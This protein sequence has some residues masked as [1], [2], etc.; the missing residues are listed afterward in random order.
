[1]NVWQL[2][3]SEVIRQFSS[4]LEGLSSS[5][6]AQRLVQ[7]GPNELQRKKE[8]KVL[9][10]L[11]S[12][13]KNAVVYILL[14]AFMIAA[15]L[16][17]WIDAG[18]IAAIVVLNTVLG[19][20]QEYKADK[21]I[22]KL[23]AL[24]TP[25]CRVMRDGKEQMIS[26]R[27]L[28]PGD[29]VLLEEGT[30]VPA[31]AYLLEAWNLKIDESLLTGESVPVKK[32]LTI[33]AEEVPV[34]GRE[35]MVFS[36][37]ITTYG[38]GKA[39]VTATGMQ[40]E[41]GKI[42]HLIQEAEEK[43]TPLQKK[44]DR[45][46]KRLAWV[47]VL[48]I[49]IIF[50]AGV[51][52]GQSWL[53]MFL[54]A[55]SLAVAAI[56][57]GLP[58]VVTISLA[59]GVRRMAK[60]R[61]LV[62]RLSAVET[63][64]ATTIICADKTGTLT[65]N[66][67]TVRKIFSNNQ[68]ID[69]TGA[70]YLPQGEFK[71]EGKSIVP[72][73]YT[74]LF[75]TALACN[76]ARLENGKVLGDPTEGALVVVAH[77]AG[78]A[79]VSPRIDEIPFTSEAKCMAT[80]HQEGEK[81]IWHYKGAPE[82]ILE[83]CAKVWLKG[84]TVPL[85]AAAKKNIVK[86][87]ESMAQDALRVLAFASGTKQNELT[88]LGL[89]GMIDPPRPSV[90]NAIQNCRQA[91]IRVVMITGDHPVTAQ[92]IA[93]K[94]GLN[95]QCLTGAALD[96]MDDGA[97]K[98]AAKNVDIYARVSPAHKVRILEALRDG[99]IIAMTGDGVNDA[100]ALKRADIGVAVGSATD[101]AKE[102][103]DMVLLDDDFSLIVGA[104]EEGRGIYDNIKKFVN[105][106]LSSNLGEVL[107]LFLAMMIGFSDAAGRIL[108]PLLAVHLLWINLVTDGLPA[109]ALGADPVSANVM[110]RKPRNPKEPLITANMAGNMGITALLMAAGGLL[111]FSKHQNQ[112][113][114][115]QTAVFTSIVVFEMVR[116]IMIR[117]QYHLPLFSN[118]WLVYAV[119]AS[120]ALQLLAVYMP[121][122]QLAFRTVPL[123]LV[124]WGQIV[125][126][127]AVLFIGGSL[128]NKMLTKMTRQ[129]D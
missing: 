79:E 38:R 33:I 107:L 15:F 69:V 54:V 37:T 85:N 14:A 49:L 48:I 28:V 36:S 84:R 127:A 16:Q 81:R 89:I 27:N 59:L 71:S 11:F 109:L 83:K 101:V 117:K 53:G 34:S 9:K 17:E 129:N 75:Q 5:D 63:L 110:Q 47:T 98:Q 121:F 118:R 65:C 113:N 61:V 30:K 66:E 23:R 57:E 115:A 25:S 80:L 90:E 108:I 111:L 10:I 55:I 7:H 42:A 62:R 45:M 99:Q 88:F 52:R 123:N 86:A 19:F 24:A 6:A 126:L 51:F 70:G 91:G 40:T 72:R 74:P 39:L 64:G 32:S 21:A 41:V 68:W 125:V 35:N 13:L 124:I 44:L 120:L 60:K 77:K 31:D 67:M 122:F 93:H 92:A 96:Q 119:I 103:A 128:G 100:P 58:A 112:L 95:T 87:N 3:K 105:Y 29:V 2:E 8:S 4:S 50:A 26:T 1:M 22:E 18:V 97:V 76:N 102:S 104:V 56:P 114:M 82:V 20:M 12:Q 43:E 94:I 106:L 46:G 78:V 73:I 116:I